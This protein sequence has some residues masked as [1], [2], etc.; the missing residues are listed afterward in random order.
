MR[1]SRGGD[2]LGA[3]VSVGALCAD[4]PVSEPDV[5]VGASC[6]LIWPQKA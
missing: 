4:A 3:D 6:E 1:R 2:A 5:G